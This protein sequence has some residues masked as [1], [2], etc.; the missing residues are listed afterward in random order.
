MKL[1][2]SQGATM[3][4]ILKNILIIITSIFGVLLVFGA[5]LLCRYVKK[6][7][8]EEKSTKYSGTTI[9][10]VVESPD[11]QGSD[12]D[13][14]AELFPPTHYK[15]LEYPGTQPVLEILGGDKEDNIRRLCEAGFRIILPTYHHPA[16][17]TWINAVS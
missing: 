3:P 10:K 11:G 8:K 13:K 1:L 14:V 17:T 5:I 9:F 16:C 15:I 6:M 7:E 2:A 4:E 12:T